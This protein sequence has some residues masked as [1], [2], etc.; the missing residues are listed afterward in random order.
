MN[1]QELIAYLSDYI[2][3]DLDEALHAEAQQ[4]LATCHDCHVVLD[5]TQRTILLYRQAYRDGIPQERRSR[6]FDR[7]QRSLADRTDGP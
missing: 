4:H 7:L 5:T 3:R 6:L 2:D 1:C